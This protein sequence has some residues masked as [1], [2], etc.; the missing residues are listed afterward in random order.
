MKNNGQ[1][2]TQNLK[3]LKNQMNQISSSS[4][5]LNNAL[6]QTN[7][8]IGFEINE[9]KIDDKKNF[10]IISNEIDANINTII[11]KIK[12]NI[13]LSCSKFSDLNQ[14]IIQAEKQ[15]EKRHDEVKEIFNKAEEQNE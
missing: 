4:Q 7:A 3:E 5:E 13:A 6:N 1:I 2:F 8:L 15:D 10:G 12:E 11:S 9:K 14:I